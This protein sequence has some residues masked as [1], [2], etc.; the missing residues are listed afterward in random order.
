[1][2]PQRTK[3]ICYC[4]APTHFYW[5]HYNYYLEHPGFGLFNPLA[6]LGLR[7]LVGP[8]RRWDLK[9]SKRPEIFI[10]NSSHTQSEIKKYYGGHRGDLSASGHRALYHKEPAESAVWVCDGRTTDAG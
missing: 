5:R 6:R 10:A 8:L 7:L 1:M 9:A 3:H 2:R 4:H